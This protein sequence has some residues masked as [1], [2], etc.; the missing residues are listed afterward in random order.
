MTQKMIKLTATETD[1]FAKNFQPLSY[2]INF[3]IFFYVIIIYLVR[4]KSLTSSK[5]KSNCL[6]LKRLVD[7]YGV[8]ILDC[9]R[10]YW[11]RR[12]RLL[13]CALSA[14]FIYIASK[15]L[16]WSLS[17]SPPKHPNFLSKSVV[18]F[19]ILARFLKLSMELIGI[20]S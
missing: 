3:I 1:P 4:V 8:N 18:E 10:H 11:T 2:A 9:R 17:E 16:T 13:D 7:I 19:P 15:K 12:S 6:E 14:Q 20:S 5:S